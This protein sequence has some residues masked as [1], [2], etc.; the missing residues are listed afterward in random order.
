MKSMGG[1]GE[2]VQEQITAAWSKWQKVSGVVCDKRMS[3]KLRV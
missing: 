2:D 1:T 3:T